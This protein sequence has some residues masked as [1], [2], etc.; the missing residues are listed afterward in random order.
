M[1]MKASIIGATNNCPLFPCR[2]TMPS[3]QPTAFSYEPVSS[4]ITIQNSLPTSQQEHVFR[5]HV[6]LE[7]NS[8]N[9]KRT[10]LKSL[11]E[12]VQLGGRRF[13]AFG[14]TVVGAME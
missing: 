3:G 2:Q 9:L 13:G 4:S 12:S 8:K 14:L 1:K 5:K 6:G 10:I 11:Y 7:A